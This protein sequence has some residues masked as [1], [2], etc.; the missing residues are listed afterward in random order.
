MRRG[1]GHPERPVTGAV[2]ATYDE[3]GQLWIIFGTGRMWGKEDAYPCGPNAIPDALANGKVA[4]ENAYA[5][6]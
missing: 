1:L 2:N 3:K 4:G 5:V 6:K